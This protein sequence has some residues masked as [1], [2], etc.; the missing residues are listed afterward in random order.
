MPG[1]DRATSRPTKARPDVGR[2]RTI[3]FAGLLPLAVACA[4]VPTADRGVAVYQAPLG[5]PASDA[6]MPAGCRRLA[7]HAR[8]NL[9]ELEMTGSKDPFRA[10][11]EGAAAAGGNLLLVRSRILVPRQGFDCP[12][13]SPIT[14]CPPTEGAWFEVV[15]EDYACSADALQAL[16]KAAPPT[17]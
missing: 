14:D 4:S 1:A 16:Q 7:V 6:R 8:V 10:H 15:F 5:G 9:T 12:A 17:P 13:A 2:V 11:R 3:A